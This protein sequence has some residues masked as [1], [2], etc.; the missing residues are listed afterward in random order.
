MENA[1]SLAPA[2]PAAALP[3]EFLLTPGQ[4]PDPVTLPFQ[5]CL[6]SLDGTGPLG[7]CIASHPTPSLEFF[8]SRQCSLDEARLTVYFDF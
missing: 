6:G 5:T 7:I 2:R 1:D 8:L 3:L 4:V